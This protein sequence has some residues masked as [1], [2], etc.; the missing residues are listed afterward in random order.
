MNQCQHLLKL[1]E[2]WRSK[3][4][5]LKRRHG[6]ANPNLIAHVE[7]ALEGCAEELEAELHRVPVPNAEVSEAADEKR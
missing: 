5:D 3:A 2:G 4:A 6:K 1:A 7:A